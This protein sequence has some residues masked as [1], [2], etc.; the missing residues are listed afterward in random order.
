MAGFDMALQGAA[1]DADDLRIVVA[2]IDHAGDQAILARLEG[3]ALALAGARFS[4]KFLNLRHFIVLTVP[5]PQEGA[6]KEARL[7]AEGRPGRNRTLAGDAGV[8]A[9]R[10]RG[11][12]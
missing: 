6:P 2:A 5:R 11:K 10:K 7:I 1:I 8:L 4:L 12:I 3:R 9:C